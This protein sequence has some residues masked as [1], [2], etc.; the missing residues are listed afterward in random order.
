MLIVKHLEHM[1]RK[2]VAASRE[3]VKDIY[4]GQRPA[5]SQEPFL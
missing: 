5:I 3:S 2:G 4:S 1:I